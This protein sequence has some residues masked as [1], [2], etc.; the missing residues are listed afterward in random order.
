MAEAAKRQIREKVAVG[1]ITAIILAALGFLCKSLLLP[2]A[3]TTMSWV[4]NV[5][6]E[7]FSWLFHGNVPVP[8][9]LFCFLCAGSLALLAFAVSKI[10]RGIK[11]RGTHWTDYTEDHFFGMK[12]RWRF[13]SSGRISDLWC[14]CPND[15]TCLVYKDDF[16]TERSTGMIT[17]A[18]GLHCETCGQTFGPHAGDTDSLKAKVERQICRK[19]DTNEWHTI[20]VGRGAAHAP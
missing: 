1:V 19:L 13:S 14:F 20:V 2:A 15:Q 11:I 12:W 7:V 17:P 18:I 4:W 6:K 8:A 16:I 9:W 5:T 3:T 10:P